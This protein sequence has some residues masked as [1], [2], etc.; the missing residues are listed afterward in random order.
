MTNIGALQIWVDLQVF[1]EVS[2][3]INMHSTFLELN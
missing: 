1:G 3:V 2:L